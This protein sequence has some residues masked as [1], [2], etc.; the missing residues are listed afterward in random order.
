MKFVLSQ[1]LLQGTHSQKV[2]KSLKIEGDQ[3]TLPKSGLANQ[4]HMVL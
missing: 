3:V 1:S 2:S 4:V